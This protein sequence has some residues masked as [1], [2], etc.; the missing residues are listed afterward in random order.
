MK[1]KQEKNGLVV[2][3][4]LLENNLE[5]SLKKDGTEISSIIQYDQIKGDRITITKSAK[6]TKIAA[7]LLL[8]FFGVHL[9][10]GNYLSVIALVSRGS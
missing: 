2:E 3:I 5:Y 7:I 10:L 9:L 8:S 1:F 6:K 4:K